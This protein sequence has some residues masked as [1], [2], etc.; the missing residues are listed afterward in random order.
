VPPV[1]GRRVLDAGCGAGRTTAWLVEQGAEVTGIELSD[2]GDYFA[3]E[4]L[5]DVWTVAGRE[6]EVRFW[7]RPLS[8]MF[9]EIAEA[10][11]GSTS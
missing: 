3:L 10:A 1:A 2:T 8:R 9:R 5:C 4:L 6:R 11:G 7:H